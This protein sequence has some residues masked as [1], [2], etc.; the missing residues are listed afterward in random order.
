MVQAQ[1]WVE[2]LKI[3]PK[4]L[5]EWETLAP[6]GVPVLVYV[7]QEGHVS[8]DHY[9]AWASQHY[10]I[11]VLGE[12][13][14][15]NA[16][17][18]DNA[19]NLQFSMTYDWKPWIF[20]VEQWEGVTYVACVEP[21]ATPMG[22]HVRVVLADPRTMQRCWSMIA[23]SFTSTTLDKPAEFDEKAD[24]PMG[25]NIE[26]KA[27]KLD[28]GNL[29]ESQL[30]RKDGHYEAPPAP[31][32]EPE[33][34]AVAEA[35]VIDDV[36]EAQPEMPEFPESSQ[37]AEIP[38]IPE[39]PDAPEVSEVSEASVKIN[40]PPPPPMA[41]DDEESSP[42][43][44]MPTGITNVNKLAD[45]DQSVP[46]AP[47]IK[48]APPPVAKGAPPPL[49]KEAQSTDPDEVFEKL[50]AIYQH[51]FLMK[52]TKEKAKLYK[53]DKSVKPV[54]KAVE[55]DLGFPT[56]LRIIAKTHL[57]Y[58]GYLVDSP[59]HRDFFNSL[60]LPE[61]PG[62]VTGI[63]INGDNEL[64]GVLV[65]VGDESLQK[66]DFLKKAEAISQ[67]MIATLQSTWAASAAA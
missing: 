27:F 37:V 32:S 54:S 49:T 33:P 20:P 62:C 14:F 13:F 58:H 28:L 26:T 25:M 15:A 38:D 30:F 52:C 41:M 19:R 16:F 60:K 46:A 23:S 64:L 51:V 29:D 3:S 36:V 12:D 59:A 1:T 8:V 65:C 53:W 56:F 34:E 50:K 45:D 43:H 11:P 42:L 4:K 61:L 2:A 6:D 47:A 17:D 10:N 44:A 55:V 9:L 31:V 67:A 57:P 24:A 63:P 22:D 35:E 7:L 21:P 66:L 18:P 5:K 39:I 48:K 40:V